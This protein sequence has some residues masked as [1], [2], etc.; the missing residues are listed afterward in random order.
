MNQDL[1][2]H[3]DRQRT[4]TS[5]SRPQKAA[6]ASS[7]A[8]QAGPDLFQLHMRARPAPNPLQYFKSV[9]LSSLHRQKSWRFGSHANKQKNTADGTMPLSDIHRQLFAPMF[10]SA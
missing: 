5:H 8:P 4:G 7:L 6:P 10:L 1:Q 3:A 9:V 2:Y